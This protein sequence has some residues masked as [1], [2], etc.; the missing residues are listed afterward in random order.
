MKEKTLYLSDLDGTLLHSDQTISPYTADVINRLTAAGML[1]SYATARSFVTASKV[2]KG[3]STPIPLIIYNGAII[4][5]NGTGKMLMSNFFSREESDQILDILLE[6][7]LYPIVY[8]FV[9]GIEKF[10]YVK[11]LCTEGM[12]DFLDTRKGDKRDNPVSIGS[13]G[14]GDIFYFNCI[15]EEEKLLPVHKQ[16]KDKFSCVYS[17][18]IYSGTQWLEIMPSG[19]TKASAALQLKKMLGCEK[20]VCFGDGKNDLSL[21]EISDECYAVENADEELKQAA[22]AVIGSCDNDGVAKWL[23]KNFI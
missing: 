13:L 3:I 8:A 20:I 21:F 14:K 22:T 7:K 17:K 6:N 15:D 5:E 19:A 23:E 9:D 4:T 2:T 12:N 1:F 11:E 16:L 10:S 18:D